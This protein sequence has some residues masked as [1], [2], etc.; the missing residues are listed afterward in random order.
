VTSGNFLAAI[1]TALGTRTLKLNKNA[2][3]SIWEGSLELDKNVT[4][5]RYDL[6]VSGVDDYGNIANYSTWFIVRNAN[7]AFS[8]DI[9]VTTNYQRAK[10]TAISVFV[11]YPSGDSL[12]AND[13]VSILFVQSIEDANFSWNLM[14]INRTTGDDKILF[15]N[16]LQFTKQAPLGIYDTRLFA[17]DPYGNLGTYYFTSSLSPAELVVNLTSNKEQIQI[18]F[19]QIVIMGNIFFPDGTMLT[20]GN[21]SATASIDSHSSK[22]SFNYEDGKK[23]VGSFSPSVF[24]PAGSYLISI[25]AIDAHGNSGQQSFKISASQTL[26]TISVAMIIVSIGIVLTPLVRAWLRRT[27]IK[28]T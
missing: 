28:E 22:I 10:P 13:N 15:S 17:F 19:D 11:K 8:F 3:S 27:R 23:W 24:D 18:G 7:L 6:F 5:G 4:L 21:V 20:E 26:L 2:N 1:S 25:I 9:P 12:S 14:A 16:E